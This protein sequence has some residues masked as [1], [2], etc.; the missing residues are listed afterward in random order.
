MNILIT[1]AAGFVGRKL[2]NHLLGTP[3]LIVDGQERTLQQL[4]LWDVAPWDLPSAPDGIEINQVI[5]DLQDS[6]RLA[7]VFAGGIDAVIHLAAVV[8]SAAETDFD[9]GVAVNF[10]ATRSLL[11][12]CRHQGNAPLFMFASSVAVFGGTLPDVISDDTAP[13]PQS[14]YGTQKAMCELLVNDYSR[15]GY[16]NGRTLRLPTIIIR[17]GKPNKAASTFA[18]SIIREPLNGE[19]A[20]CP[21][22]AD[23]AMFVQ[24]PRRVVKAF[25]HGIGLKSEDFGSN[26]ILNLPG[27]TVTVTQMIEA[28]HSARGD[29]AVDLISWDND[30][31]I[32]AIVESWPARFDTA[33]ASSLGFCADDGMD[34]ILSIFI[35][36]EMPA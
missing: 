11:E 23:T 13:T 33:R 29:G 30:D 24:S 2:V 8:S 15:R 14:S 12:I 18:S 25:V 3:T 9:L 6:D 17:P 26:R 28:L 31:K 27:I 21:V 19:P 7:G 5:G 10:E 1:G 22:P 4:T 20:T 35:S 32:R 36:D 16:V 34:D